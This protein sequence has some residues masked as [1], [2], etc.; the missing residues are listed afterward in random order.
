[1]ARRLL[2]RLA[3]IEK[4][5]PEGEARWRE[6]EAEKVVEEYLVALEAVLGEL[7][8][9]QIE[10]LKLIPRSWG[11]VLRPYIEAAGV[12]YNPKLIALALQ[13][14]LKCG[15]VDRCEM[16]KVH[17]AIHGRAKLYAAEAR[18]H[19]L[20][21]LGHAERKE[22]RLLEMFLKLCLYHGWFGDALR[23]GALLLDPVERELLRSSFLG[24]RDV[25][26][27]PLEGLVRIALFDDL[28]CNTVLEELRQ[29]LCQA[30]RL[31]PV[32]EI[33]ALLNSLGFALW[34]QKAHGAA[35][36]LYE[37]F[38]TGLPSSS[39]LGNVLAFW[40]LLFVRS[41][42]RE[43]EEGQ[44][45][46]Q[47]KLATWVLVSGSLNSACWM[48]ESRGSQLALA[49]EGKLSVDRR[50]AYAPA[51]VECS[52][53]AITLLRRSLSLCPYLR[54]NG[55]AF[56]LG[57]RLLSAGGQG[58]T[59]STPTHHHAKSS[60][61][62]IAPSE[63]LAIERM[64]Q[65]IGRLRLEKDTLF[66]AVAQSKASVLNPVYIL[67][68]NILIDHLAFLDGLLQRQPVRIAIPSFVLIE[69]DG[70]VKSARQGKS[71]ETV[72]N[73]LD[74]IDPAAL[75]GG[76]HGINAEGRLTR[77]IRHPQGQRD[78]FPRSAEICNIDEAILHS[79]KRNGHAILV[80]DDLNLRLKGQAMQVQVLPWSAFNQQFR[81]L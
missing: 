78:P 73:Y 77:F 5:L 41:A 59:A 34:Y 30:T 10:S 60:S 52:A 80:S 63:E 32:E 40:A 18:L 49:L 20:A 75:R 22:P 25:G 23:V 21:G 1:M 39:G 48:E 74:R 26:G 42:Q 37:T 51:G 38:L 29:R 72:A 28:R 31:K 50:L 16:V 11:L 44:G 13:I 24:P 35:I 19:L 46:A 55:E 6:A 7:N 66:Q 68:T 4:R 43:E 14:Y 64:R 27:D 62:S 76:L 71:A 3:L 67:D 2:K 69:L 15:E 57:P 17:V 53:V 45:L 9:V 54:F 70:L 79:A 8:E 61:P 33:A 36:F 65:E 58:G 47:V 56:V 81:D 12:Q